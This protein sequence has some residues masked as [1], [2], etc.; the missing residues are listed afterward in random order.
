MARIIRRVSPLAATAVTFTVLCHAGAMVT[1]RSSYADFQPYIGF[2]LAFIVLSAASLALAVA[3]FLVSEITTFR[4]LLGIRVATVLLLS[5]SLQEHLL[6][7]LLFSVSVM[8][9]ISIY[10]AFPLNLS[11]NA[12]FLIVNIG[13]KT[14]FF[15]ATHAP[16]FLALFIVYTLVCGIVAIAGGFL[17]R[18]FQRMID[19]G[20]EIGKLDRA[21][22]DLSRASEGY[23]Q[24][25]RTAEER[26]IKAERERLTRELHDSTGYTFTNIIMLTEAAK[27]LVDVDTTRLQSKLDDACEM[28]RHGLEETRSALYELRAQETRRLRGINAING[29]VRTFQGATAVEVHV[30]Y[31]N[32]RASYG[33]DVDGAVYHFVQEALTNSFRHGKA[34]KILIGFWENRENLEIWIQD[35]GIGAQSVQEGIGISGM[36]ERLGKL[37]GTLSVSST[38]GG[39]KLVAEIPLQD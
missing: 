22:T 36:R 29:L 1:W 26:S 17:L 5:F 38:D 11:M 34:T 6:L 33:D 30:E 18:Y 21:F 8:F 20:L 16:R 15:F 7:L 27:A 14:R 4:I 9:E 12:V 25:A 35:D 2:E 37:G 32:M 19:Y 31:A 39:F 24:F 28:A 13:L 10:E 23:L 3:M